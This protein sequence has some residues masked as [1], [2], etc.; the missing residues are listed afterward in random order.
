[1]RCAY[2]HQPIPDE[3]HPYTL[4]LE[5]FPAIE[6]SLQ[7]SEAELERDLEAEMKR[8][9]ELME[10]MDEDQVIEQEK[11]MFVSHTFMLCRL[12]RDRLARELERLGPPPS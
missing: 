10:R 6:P 7:V 3:M 2:C 8:L 5:L 12:C 11:R 1:M 4:R 9:I